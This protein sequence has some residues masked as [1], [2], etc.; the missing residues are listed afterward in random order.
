MNILNIPNKSQTKPLCFSNLSNVENVKKSTIKITVPV[1]LIFR[2]SFNHVS[3][4]FKF[5]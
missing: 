1:F 4:V 2:I 3:L 5:Y